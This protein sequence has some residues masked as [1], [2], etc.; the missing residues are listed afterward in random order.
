MQGAAATVQLGE[1]LAANL[2]RALELHIKTLELAQP[3]IVSLTEAVEDGLLDDLRVA[4]RAIE[5]GIALSEQVSQQMATMNSLLDGTTQAVRDTAATASGVIES[6]PA[7]RLE[8]AQLREAVDR[9]V[10]QMTAVA[11]LGAI[12]GMGRALG[13]ASPPFSRQPTRPE[14]AR[15]DESPAEH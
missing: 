11:P 7:T 6:L 4:L 10:G 14:G 5:A 15:S 3:L 9:M 2:E 1:R 13:L 8:L 12:P